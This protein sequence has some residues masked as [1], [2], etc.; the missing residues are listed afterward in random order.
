MFSVMND[1]TPR[2]AVPGSACRLLQLETPGTRPVWAVLDAAGA[3]HFTGEVV[4]HTEPRVVVHFDKGEAYV[5]ERDGDPALGGRLV[6]LGVLTADQLD[7]GLVRLGEVEHLGRLFDRVPDVDRDRV[8]LA[9]EGITAE[10]LGEIA[11]HPVDEISVASY[12]HHPSGVHRW[13]H[14]PVFVVA[15]LGPDSADSPPAASVSDPLVATAGDVA[16]VAEYE[17]LL[18]DVPPVDQYSPTIALPVIAPA[19]E[20]AEV[21]DA[22]QT[23]ADEPQHPEWQ[24][25]AVEAS[26]SWPDE[27]VDPE[28]EPLVA[29]LDDPVGVFGESTIIWD[30]PIDGEPVPVAPPAD[31]GGHAVPP[32]PVEP[33]RTSGGHGLEMPSFDVAS[34][35][36][37]MARDG[38]GEDNG[39]GMV[40]PDLPDETDVDD[41]VRAAVRAALAEI[42]AATR[43]EMSSP[44]ETLPA[45]ATELGAGPGTE[46][47]AG[48]S[49]ADAPAPTLGGASPAVTVPLPTPYLPGMPRLGSADPATTGQ[50][51][52]DG[53]EFDL[54]AA[55]ASVAADLPAALDDPGRPADAGSPDTVSTDAGT[56]DA[57][58]PDAV[59]PDAVSIDEQPLPPRREDQPTGGLRRLIGIRKP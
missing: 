27:L 34:I 35:M 23:A 46:P 29:T 59:S 9:L 58:S 25:W 3:R 50:T 55:I 31:D 40:L 30:L 36:Q 2:C 11:D 10:V 4:L 53:A 12:R 20:S 26:M 47:G 54:G 52:P 24:E 49:R 1:A 18:A 42:E 28:P 14:R 5:A 8:E 43:S 21:T 17:R 41:D 57:V 15:S 38:A 7:R 56:P 39:T 13:L 19:F 44:T 33:T 51:S 16:L 32:E 48:E 37:Q 45:F 6:E 22:L